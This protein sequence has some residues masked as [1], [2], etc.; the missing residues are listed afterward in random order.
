MKVPFLKP[1]DDGVEDGE[2]EEP[3]D[4]G[5]A[6]GV[7]NGAGLV[8]DDEVTGG[9]TTAIPNWEDGGVRKLRAR[10]IPVIVA[11]MVTVT[12]TFMFFSLVIEKR[13]ARREF[14]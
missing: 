1:T 6:E 10:V 2:G 4:G 11:K 7:D 9:G 13:S 5:A 14:V 12:R 3:P 8:A